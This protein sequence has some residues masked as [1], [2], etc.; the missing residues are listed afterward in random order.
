MR[1]SHDINKY[2]WIDTHIYQYTYY[3]EHEYTY[4]DVCNACYCSQHV[5]NGYKFSIFDDQ[6]AWNCDI[7]KI[8]DFVKKST[9]LLQ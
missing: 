3:R 8:V 5:Q 4:K 6:R 9:Q 2:V 7:L 1:Q